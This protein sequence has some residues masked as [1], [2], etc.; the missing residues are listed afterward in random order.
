MEEY[1]YIVD[2]ISQL[3]F[4][5]QRSPLFHFSKYS[6]QPI[7]RIYSDSLN[8]LKMSLQTNIQSWPNIAMLFWKNVPLSRSIKWLPCDVISLFLYAL[9]FL[10]IGSY[11]QVWWQMFNAWLSESKAGIW[12]V[13]QYPWCKYFHSGWFQATN[14]ISLNTQGL[15]W[16]SAA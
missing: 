5:S 6:S 10:S 7:L 9:Y 8:R 14:A 15:L 4:S 1:I 16:W 11:T 12:G 3:F 13:G 2:T